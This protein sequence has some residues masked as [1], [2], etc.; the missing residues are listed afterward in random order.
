[1]TAATR[2]G[3]SVHSDVAEGLTPAPSLEPAVLSRSV[4]LQRPVENVLEHLFG[5][6]VL[7]SLIEHQPLDDPAAKAE[8]VES[9][10]RVV[11]ERLCVRERV[12]RCCL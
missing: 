11:V 6:K 10:V 4:V 8:R 2:R 9:L 7:E 5:A 3:V 12:D 1:V